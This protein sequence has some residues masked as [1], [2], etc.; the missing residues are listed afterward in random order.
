[1]RSLPIPLLTYTAY[2]IFLDISL[3][4]DEN[5]KL[6]KLSTIILS[7]SPIKIYS[8]GLLLELLYELQL[9][10]L[11]NKMNPKN[12]AI[13][14]GNNILKSNELDQSKLMKDQTKITNLTE[15]LIL[16][17]PKLKPVFFEN[18]AITNTGTVERTIKKTPSNPP[19]SNVSPGGNKVGTIKR[20]KPLPTLPPVIPTNNTIPTQ[21]MNS[22]SKPPNHPP[23]SIPP[24]KKDLTSPL[25]TSPRKEVPTTPKD[26]LE[27]SQSDKKMGS[28]PGQFNTI[29]SSSTF[30][31]A[32]NQFMSETKT[33]PKEKKRVGSEKK[34]IPSPSEPKF[35]VFVDDDEHLLTLKDIKNRLPPGWDVYP[36]DEGDDIYFYH[37]STQE[38]HWDTPDGF[39]TLD[40]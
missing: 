12:L 4:E 16:L 40:L 9:N 25:P 18:K 27:K 7:L 31:N 10:S 28:G 22:T 34:M 24:L 20:V 17:F 36:T 35:S 38:S 8:L 15:S 23:P 6:E 32:K 29:S 39:H 1:L 26:K 33:P 3:I 19:M 30:Q 37:I 2:D 14:F 13:V 5:V 11:V 21:K